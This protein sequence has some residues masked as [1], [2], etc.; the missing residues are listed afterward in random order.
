MV[1]PDPQ[2]WLPHV[3]YVPPK[4]VQPER[5]T[6]QVSPQN[7]PFKIAEMVRRPYARVTDSRYMTMY[8]IT[9]NTANQYL[10]P[11]WE[12]RRLNKRQ[13]RV[14]EQAGFPGFERDENNKVYRVMKKKRI[15]DDKSNLQWLKDRCEGL[16]AELDTSFVF[17]YV[18]DAM[19]ARIYLS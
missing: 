7:R 4:Q 13:S 19:K 3:E 12:W 6:K 11:Y 16:F 1:S 10:L 18:E 8:E 15:R 2:Y 14:L 5:E 9:A 17:Q